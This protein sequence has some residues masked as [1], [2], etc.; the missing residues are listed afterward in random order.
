MRDLQLRRGMSVADL[1]RQMGE[2]GGFTAQKIAEAAGVLSRAKREGHRTVLSIP[3]AP[4]ATGLRGVVRDL[5]R[6][7]WVQAIVTTCGTLDH[8]LARV[9]GH[10]HQ[11]SFEMDDERLLEEDVHRLGSVLV[12]VSSYGPLLE[13]KLQPWLSKLYDEKKTWGGRELVAAFGTLLTGEPRAEESVLHHAARRGVP[14]FVP[15]FTDGAVGSQLWQFRSRRKDFQ[16]DLLRDEEELDAFVHG[17][18]GLGAVLVG[19]GISKHHTIWWAQ[20]RGGLDYAIAI[21]TAVEYDGSLSG[22][23]LRESVSWGKVK[24]EATKVHIDGE[25]TL[26]LPLI[27]AA[28]MDAV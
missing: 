19:G 15:G 18:G 3:A 22:A 2:S 14:V 5:V 26:V 11:G 21:T 8:D 12:P 20:F 27:A 9:W 1:V 4:F 23:R 25:A 13:E 7:G 28:A 24:P 6:D 16:L 10:Y 17:P